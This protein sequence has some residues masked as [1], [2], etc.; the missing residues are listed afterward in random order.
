[1]GYTGWIFVTSSIY[2]LTSNF[3]LFHSI[4]GFLVL[5]LGMGHKIEYVHPNTL[6]SNFDQATGLGP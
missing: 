6:G 4:L 2:V 5:K 3:V 1:M